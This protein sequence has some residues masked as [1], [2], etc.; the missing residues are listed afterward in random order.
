VDTVLKDKFVVA[1]L[2]E[3]KYVGLLYEQNIYRDLM[4]E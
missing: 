4:H 3:Q 1:S 2:G